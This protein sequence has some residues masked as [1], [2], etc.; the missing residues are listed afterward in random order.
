MRRV[1]LEAPGTPVAR[2]VR[3]IYFIRH[4]QTEFNREGRM[5]GQLDSPLTDLGV[6][7]ARRMGQRLKSLVDDPA[8]WAIIAS[9]LGRTLRTAQ[10][11]RETV[12]LTCEIE[13]DPRLAELSVGEW[14]GQTRA[15]IGARHPGLLDGP[16][17]IYGAPG[18]E[19]RLA[20]EAR[21]SD[22]LAGIDEGDGRRRLV[23]SHGAAG[24]VLRALYAGG[25]PAGAWRPD[26]PPQDAVFRLHGG[27]VARIDVAGADAP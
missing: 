20:L 15:E 12:G 26:P 3:L 10:I 22:W 4:G 13:L 5:Q 27:V 11:V 16:D 17:W 23:V 1:W 18:G 21:L 24:R 9:P 8:R 25:D 14:E 19:S 2:K 7:Q 6:E